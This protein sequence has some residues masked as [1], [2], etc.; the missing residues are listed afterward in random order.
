MSKLIMKTAAITLGALIALM[1][2][3]FGALVIFSPKTIASTAEKF[4]ND[5]VAV[6][7]Y[8]KQYLKTNSQQDLLTLCI[9][10]DENQDYA[11]TQ[12][13][14]TI[15]QGSA[16]YYLICDSNDG[17]NAEI[18]TAE[19]LNGKLAIATFYASGLEQALTVAE[20]LVKQ[21]VGYTKN[22]PFS[23]LISSVYTQLDKAELTLIRDK[24]SDLIFYSLSGEQMQNAYADFQLVQD[25]IDNAN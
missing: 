10:L 9:K 15:L 14:I 1:A 7:F 25:L 19:Y 3:I 24:I 16:D 5:K 13:Y 2:L 8:E 12:K 22:N 17:E 21:S 11:K 4:G 23:A 18:S 6:S 20:T